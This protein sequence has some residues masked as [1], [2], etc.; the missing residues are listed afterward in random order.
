MKNITIRTTHA[1]SAADLSA[2]YQYTN[3]VQIIPVSTEYWTNKTPYF[4][5]LRSYRE[6]YVILF[7]PE[8]PDQYIT[9]TAAALPNFKY[10]VQAA[11][12]ATQPSNTVAMRLYNLAKNRLTP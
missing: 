10:I 7:A 11:P 8:T 9:E 6:N 12:S 2:L 1:L 3:C 4:P 5:L